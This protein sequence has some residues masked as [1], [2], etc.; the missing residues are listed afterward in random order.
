MLTPGLQVLASLPPRLVIPVLTETVASLPIDEDTLDELVGLYQYQYGEFVP[1]QR[2]RLVHATLRA[3]A[4]H[5][6]VRMPGFFGFLLM[7]A[8]LLLPV[9]VLVSLI[10]FSG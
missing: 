8:G 1:V 10:F 7:A 3:I 9:F 5:R 6:G 4:A 2:T